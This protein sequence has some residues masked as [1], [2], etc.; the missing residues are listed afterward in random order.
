MFPNPLLTKRRESGNKAK[1]LA[2]IG[3]LVYVT[4]NHSL[5][6]IWVFKKDYTVAINITPLYFACTFIGRKDK[7]KGER[8]TRERK[9]E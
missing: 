1:Y 4:F 3:C 2:I 5:K 8:R 7:G 9:T 6:T